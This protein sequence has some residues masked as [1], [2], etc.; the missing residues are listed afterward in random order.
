MPD[1]CVFICVPLPSRDPLFLSHSTLFFIWSIIRCNASRKRRHAQ[2]AEDGRLSDAEVD[3]LDVSL[4][5]SAMARMAERVVTGNAAVAWVACVCVCMI[6][7]L[8][9]SLAL[10][11]TLLLCF[12]N[13]SEQSSCGQGLVLTKYGYCRIGL[14]VFGF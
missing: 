5:V 12:G 8:H 4:A 2:R 6:L 14:L 3:E 1:A 9:Q 11:P 13:A 10:H 7:F